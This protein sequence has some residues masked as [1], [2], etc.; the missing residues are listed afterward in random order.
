[1]SSHAHRNP[2]ERRNN[3]S[4]MGVPL[5]PKTPADYNPEPFHKLAPANIHEQ[6]M[7]EHQKGGAALVHQMP[8]SRFKSFNQPMPPESPSATVLSKRSTAGFQSLA[9]ATG[10]GVAKGLDLGRAALGRTRP[11]IETAVNRG[12][13]VV[14]PNGSGSGK[15]RKDEPSQKRNGNANASTATPTDGFRRSLYYERYLPRLAIPD[16]AAAAAGA[17]GSACSTETMRSPS[18]TIEGLSPTSRELRHLATE[19][20][21]GDVVAEIRNMISARR[22]ARKAPFG[23]VVREHCRA[24]PG[25]DDKYPLRAHDYAQDRRHLETIV[26][27]LQQQKDLAQ[28]MAKRAPGRYPGLR[29]VRNPRCTDKVYWQHRSY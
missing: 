18:W 3:N 19:E 12:K 25:W 11:A 26:A 1:M 9:K 20:D 28:D 13:Q 5:R 29:K 21:D 6:L 15:G 16:A 27:A 8:L 7:S 4:R 24:R 23:R 2:R 17:L 14:A 22:R 10:R